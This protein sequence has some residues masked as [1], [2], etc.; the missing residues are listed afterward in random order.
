MALQCDLD[1]GLKA[2]ED[3]KKALKDKLSNLT[4]VSALSDIKTAADEQLQ[5]LKDAL[6]EIPEIPD[7]QKDF[8]DLKIH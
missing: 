7:F 2:L 8:D 5:A 3:K 6:P 1:L 4:D